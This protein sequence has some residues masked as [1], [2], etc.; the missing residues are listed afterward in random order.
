MPLQNHISTLKFWHRVYSTTQYKHEKQWQEPETNDS[1]DWWL[2]DPL[3]SRLFSS[4]ANPWNHSTNYGVACTHPTIT[5]Q[6]SPFP[7][8]HLSALHQ[9]TPQ[10]NQ[11][12]HFLHQPRHPILPPKFTRI[13]ESPSRFEHKSRNRERS[14]NRRDLSSG[15]VSGE[16]GRS[17]RGANYNL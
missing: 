11:S 5:G 15:T 12:S 16:R 9:K 6:A 7:P 3:S 10:P 2:T 4:A 13:T 8:S 1:R 17:R 14:E